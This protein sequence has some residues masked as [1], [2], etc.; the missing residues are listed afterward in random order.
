MLYSS[1]CNSHLIFV[2]LHMEYKCFTPASNKFWKNYCKR[3]ISP[4][5]CVTPDM[6]NSLELVCTVDAECLRFFCAS[7]AILCN[8]RANLSGR[9]VALP[10]YLAVMYWNP[11][12]ENSTPG[13]PHCSSHSTMRQQEDLRVRHHRGSSFSPGG[14]PHIPISDW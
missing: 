4:S 6:K 7:V 14:T 12:A 2:T 9:K 8:C 1:S 10:D 5:F 11:G 3:A 13:V